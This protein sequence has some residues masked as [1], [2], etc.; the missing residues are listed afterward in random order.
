MRLRVFEHVVD[1]PECETE[2]VVV[3]VQIDEVMSL[4]VAVRLSA[5]THEVDGVLNVVG[6]AAAVAEFVGGWL[7]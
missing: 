4:D 7:R 5:K 3:D 2:R 6:S 1:G